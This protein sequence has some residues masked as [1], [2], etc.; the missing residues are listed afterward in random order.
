MLRFN[1]IIKVKKTNLRFHPLFVHEHKNNSNVM[2]SYIFQKISKHKY[3]ENN[4]SQINNSHSLI[5]KSSNIPNKSSLNNNSNDYQFPLIQS[6]ITKDKDLSKIKINNLINMNPKK[7]LLLIGN[8]SKFDLKNIYKINK[9]ENEKK[10]KKNTFNKEKDKNK[11][12]FQNKYLQI[13]LG[14]IKFR[15]KIKKSKSFFEPFEKGNKN[16]SFSKINNTETFKRTNLKL[17]FYKYMNKV[18]E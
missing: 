4:C 1:K 17:N 15:K 5:N 6:Y 8:Y 9:L 13:K 7:K 14:T 3:I 2:D 10:E 16:I 11:S 12:F 18:F